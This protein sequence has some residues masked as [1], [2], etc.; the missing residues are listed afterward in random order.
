LKAQK[1]LEQRLLILKTNPHRNKR[2]HGFKLFLFRIRFENNG[3]EK[4]VIYLLDSPNVKILFILDRNNNYKDLEEYL[5]RT[6]A[7]R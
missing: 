2:I 5:E 1:I 6:N 7:K 3:K 4:R